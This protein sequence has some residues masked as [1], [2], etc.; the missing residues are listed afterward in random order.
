[1]QFACIVAETAFAIYADPVGMTAQRCAS[2][3]PR[4]PMIEP[5]GGAPGETC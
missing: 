3:T 1:M 2:S 4:W 5:R